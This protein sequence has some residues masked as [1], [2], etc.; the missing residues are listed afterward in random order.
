M[1]EDF[2]HLF[3]DAEALRDADSGV[4]GKIIDVG[5][6][7]RLGEGYPFHVFLA[8]GSDTTAT[9]EPTI[10][11]FLESSDDEAFVDPVRFQI[12]EDLKKGDMSGGKRLISNPAPFRVRRYVRLYMEVDTAITCTNLS[13]GLAIDV[14]TNFGQI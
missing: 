4:I 3:I 1:Y 5:S 9:G 8:C 12:F 14:Q 2:N 13:A 7:D 11:F 10:R 6:K